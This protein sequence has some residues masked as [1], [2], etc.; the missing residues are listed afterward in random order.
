ME[1]EVRRLLIEYGAK[2]VRECVDKVCKSL[3]EEL[4]EMYG[5]VVQPVVVATPTAAVAAEVAATE[6]AETE[7]PKKE[8]KLR[9]VKKKEA[10][11]EAAAEV[12]TEGATE[13]VVESN[14][15]MQ[16][17]EKLNDKVVEVVT[18]KIKKKIVPPVEVQQ[19]IEEDSDSDATIPVDMNEDSEDKTNEDSASSKYPKK[20]PEEIRKDRDAHLAA[21]EAKRVEL[22]NKHISP[23]TL[24]TKE[25]LEKWLKSGLSYQRIARD[26]VGLSEKY[27]AG[28]AKNY[29]L[30]SNVANVMRLRRMRGLL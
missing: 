14:D 7:Q 13:G 25:N 18:L 19:T 27:I 15:N 29:G 2:N 11:V 28:V 12:A 22:V 26:H 21:V 4:R 23:K 6:E 30:K 24:L 5:G 10:V 20:T 17:E 9:I 8:R 1:T 16:M 3:Y